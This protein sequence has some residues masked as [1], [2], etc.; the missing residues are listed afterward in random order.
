MNTIGASLFTLFVFFVVRVS[1]LLERIESSTRM[2]GCASETST[3]NGTKLTFASVSL[4]TG[5]GGQPVSPSPAA[6]P[7]PFSF[8][9]NFFDSH[10]FPE[11]CKSNL[12]DWAECMNTNAVT[13]APTNFGLSGIDTSSEDC[14]TVDSACRA[15]SAA[16]TPCVPVLKAVLQCVGSSLGCSDTCVDVAPVA[17][18][19][20]SPVS[21]AAA[22]M[23]TNK[24]SEWSTGVEQNKAV[25][26]C[27]KDEEI[28]VSGSGTSCCPCPNQFLLLQNP[29]QI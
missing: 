9:P 2:P 20:R 27:E 1:L 5:A 25:C 13:C 23:C 21:P 19:P 24:E 6:A 22:N 29:C 12:E 7:T 10:S 16:C 18:S 15:L 11:E 17:P 14:P 8:A 28:S 3:D 26:L 4:Q